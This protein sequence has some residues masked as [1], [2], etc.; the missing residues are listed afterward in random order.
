MAMVTQP[1]V[2]KVFS[3]RELSEGEAAGAG[4]Q[5]DLYADRLARLIAFTGTQ[6]PLTVGIHGE[7]GSGKTS[8][9]RLVKGKLKEGLKPAKDFAPCKTVWFNA[10]KY[11]KHEELFVALVEEV[12]RAMEKDGFLGKVRA[13]LD[14]PKQG[15]F[16]WTGFM[17]SAVSNLVSIPLGSIVPD[18][19][20]FERES[21]F[22]KNLAFYDE[23]RS[24]FASLS[25]HFIDKKKGGRL[26]V[27]IDDLDRCL[28]HKA[29]QVLEAIKLFM[30]Q[31]DCVFVLGAAEETVAHAVQSYY[32]K[33]Q[34]GTINGHEYME[35]IVQVRFPLPP[36][37]QADMEA[38]VGALAQVDESTKNLLKLIIQGIPTNPRKIKTFLNH[39]EVQWA[40]VADA[41][42]D[43]SKKTRLVEWLVLAHPDVAPTFRA[44]V[45]AANS[46]KERL[47]LITMMKKIADAT[48]DEQRDLLNNPENKQFT[49]FASNQ[50]LM[51]VLKS[52]G[53]FF[54][55][56]DIRLCVNLIPP[57]A[58]AAPE[59]TPAVARRP[60]TREEVERAVAEGRNLRGANLRGANLRDA[61]LGGADLGSA[62]LGGADL[63]G[64]DLRDAHL[65]GADLRGAD[66]G[67]ADLRG[68]NLGG[69]D[70]RGAN[71]GGADLRYTNL[72]GAELRYA[73]L[74]GAIFDPETIDLSETMGW[75]EA[76]WDPEV[77]EILLRRFG[78]G[79]EKTTSKE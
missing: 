5:F 30:D 28:P 72:M 24:A 66:L 7:W 33:E 1:Y 3:D 13:W 12:L 35:K 70:L 64:A 11:A 74:T 75:R 40:L 78:R 68:A 44:A 15:E 45:K 52:S 61:H 60:L 26:V 32:A 16:N 65:G 49:E 17:A 34:M 42:R 6:V 22:R 18:A 46:D 29:V 39:V 48:G 63:G 55:L 62:D 27:F 50:R 41:A 14:D 59:P 47:G 25:D 77:L 67:G 36:I 37:R 20:Q 2:P 19:S 4:F 76:R 9:M 23:F 8:L 54:S 51:A 71:L 73:N 58:L 56:E 10:W 31:Q 53:F 79:E 21:S 38:Y 57:P 43:A 69:A